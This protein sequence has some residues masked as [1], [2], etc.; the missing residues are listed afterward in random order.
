MVSGRAGKPSEATA[1]RGGGQ[2][3]RGAGSIH[4]SVDSGIY[5]LDCNG[6]GVGAFKNTFESE[7]K[8]ARSTGIF[9]LG[10]QITDDDSGEAIRAVWLFTRGAA[11]PKPSAKA[12]ADAA[13][14][15]HAA[16]DDE[17]VFG[18]VRELAT[19]GEYLTRRALRDHARSASPGCC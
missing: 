4:G 7:I 9:T 1:K 6:D 19:R 8:G 2:R 10:L 5:F 12:A 18:F 16:A 14:A 3:L 17:K 15:E 13:T 11:A